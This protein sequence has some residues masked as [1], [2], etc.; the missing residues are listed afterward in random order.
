MLNAVHVSKTHFKYS[1]QN[2]GMCVCVCVLASYSQ[3]CSV[4]LFMPVDVQSPVNEYIILL[5]VFKVAA[6][7]VSLAVKR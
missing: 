2:H 1:L 7:I 4:N 6:A 5:L 3:V